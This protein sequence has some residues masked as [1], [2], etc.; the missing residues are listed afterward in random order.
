MRDSDEARERR[1]AELAFVRSA[2]D[3][4]TEA[5]I[6]ENDEEDCRA[7]DDDDHGGQ[8]FG[9][10]AAVIVR[11]LVAL[12]VDGG[13]DN[14][15]HDSSRPSTSFLL[16]LELPYGYPMNASLVVASCT[17]ERCARQLQPRVV[18]A[19]AHALLIACRAVVVAVPSS[20]LD[21]DNDANHHHFS[22]EGEEAVFAILQRADEW[23]AEEW[24]N[25]IASQMEEDEA[26]RNTKNKNDAAVRDDDEE[27]WGRNLIYS[28][29]IIGQQKRADMKALAADLELTGYVKIGWP[30]LIVIEGLESHCRIFYDTIRRWAWQYLVLRGEMR[31]R[32]IVPSQQSASSIMRKFPTFLE[33]DSMS[34][35]A[36]HCRQVG[37]EELFLTSMKV[38]ANS[39]QQVNASSD[40]SVD[41]S[42]SFYGALVHVDH[43]NDAKQYRKWLRRTC[44]DLNVWLLIRQCFDGGDSLTQA[45]PRMIVVGLVGMD[46]ASVTAVLKKWRGA[47]VDVDRRGLPCLE[48]Q[49]TV[50]IQGPLDASFD[51]SLWEE[52]A[53]R[54]DNN[55]SQINTTRE[56]L[57]QL[58]E[59]S[60]QT[61]SW[62]DAI[63]SLLFLPSP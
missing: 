33:V 2:Y 40:A 63:Q 13:D 34:V 55:T 15:E 17:V 46:E 27:W 21:D 31:E 35:V 62:V 19:A 22:E 26:R 7:D 24:P 11:R 14:D 9:Q 28:H 45:R 60:T 59:S 50:L 48:R 23:M 42:T 5:W 36:E 41:E 16:R 32:I 52:T 54:S 18:H 8:H 10:P 56:K 37:L 12:G 61:K 25:F 39:Q 43:M 44:A 57:V 53:E 30:G 4:E 38:Q 1:D 6:I 58:I 49:M 47:K 29:H 20:T 3:A 51:D